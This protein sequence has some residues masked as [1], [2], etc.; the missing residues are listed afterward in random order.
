MTSE[1]LNFEVDKVGYDPISHIFNTNTCYMYSKTNLFAFYLHIYCKYLY[2]IK[3][4]CHV[5]WIRMSLPLVLLSVQISTKRRMR[6]STNKIKLT[7]KLI[8][9]INTCCK[10]LHTRNLLYL[11]MRWSA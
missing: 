3:L 8:Y 6:K 11:Y 10:E 5:F 1:Y 7:I 2:K 9:E 4:N